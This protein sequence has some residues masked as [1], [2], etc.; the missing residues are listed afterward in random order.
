MEARRMSTIC[1]LIP[2]RRHSQGFP[3]KNRRL[4]EYGAIPSLGR[5]QDLIAVTTDD[6]ILKLY[7]EREGFLVVD[8]PDHLATDTASMAAVV[9]H[10]CQNLPSHDAVLIWQLTQPCRRQSTVNKAIQQWKDQ[11]EKGSV[12]TV[13]RVPDHYLPN[14]VVGVWGDGS[15][16]LPDHPAARR[17][18]ARPAYIRD[19]QAYVLTWRRALDADWYKGL[20]TAVIDDPP[21][22]PPIDSEQDWIRAQA[23][24]AE[25]KMMETTS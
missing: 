23:W 7:A 25:Q 19:G 18:D 3:G 17:Q 20:C 21:V 6:P 14:R 24:L 12:I 8:R 13:Q 15:M 4:W 5:P 2:A 16:V 10:A 9:S 22:P 11:R 1:T